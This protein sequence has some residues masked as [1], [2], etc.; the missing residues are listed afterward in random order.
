MTQ[1]PENLV[2]LWKIVHE[3]AGWLSFLVGRLGLSDGD[4]QFL[5]NLDDVHLADMKRM[6]SEWK[7]S[8]TMSKIAE[9]KVEMGE[10]GRSRRR[11]YLEGRLVDLKMLAAKFI[12][13]GGDYEMAACE[14]FEIGIEKLRTEIEYLSRPMTNIKRITEYQIEQARAFPL[15]RLLESRGEEITRGKILCPFHED[16][17]PSMTVKGGYGYCFVCA[18]NLD[19]IGYLMKICGMSFKSAVEALQ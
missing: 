13:C 3:R 18:K 16:K 5:G 9:L 8:D 4:I 10:W 7:R 14:R 17:R 12:K 1:T 19:S 2:E 6:A 15:E 11:A